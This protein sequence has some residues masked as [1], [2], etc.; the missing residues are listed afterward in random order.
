ML[1]AVILAGGAGTRFW[2]LSRRRRPKQLLPLGGETSLLRQ[3]FARLEGL[4][5]PERTW[6]I[7]SAVLADE[8]RREL[9]ELA[10]E[11]IVGEP[12]RRDT[13]LATA[14]GAALV[15]ARDPAGVLAVLPADHVIRPRERFQQDLAAAAA[16][17]EEGWI[18]TFGIRPT[19]P[20]TGYGYI[21]R[22]DPLPRE[23]SIEAY[24]VRAFEEKPDQARAERYL[25]AGDRFWNSGIFVWGAQTVLDGLR[26]HRPGLA[27]A[28]EE[29]A[30]AWE[31]S[32]RDAA[33]A[34]AYA[35]AERISID[36]ALLERAERLAVVAAT[37]EW[38]DVGSWSAVPALL[39]RNADGNAVAGGPALALDARDCLVW[40]DG[41]LVALLGVRDLVVV[42]TPEATLVAHRDRA[43]EVKAL[44]DRLEGTGRTDLL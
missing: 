41:R 23:G 17:A 37:F 43:E 44:V 2:P 12:E 18:V 24:V 9:P 27:E 34:R 19:H 20:H 30:G 36:Y 5:P 33:L 8:V 26:R 15:R 39:G 29:V 32:D 35:D 3:T 42:E 14:L 38:S 13:G 25:A 10:P 28:A 40:S 7:T 22:G 21:A 1:H 31:R 6:V 11:R 16:L 4:V